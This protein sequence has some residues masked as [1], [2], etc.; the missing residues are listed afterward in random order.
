[1]RARGTKPGRGLRAK[2]YRPAV[3][4]TALG[5]A[6]LAAQLFGRDASEPF[7]HDWFWAA[8]TSRLTLTCLVIATGS[9]AMMAWLGAVLWRMGRAARAKAVNTGQTGSAM[10]EF[11]MVLPILLVF[12]L[13]MTQSALLVTGNVVVHYSAFCAARSAIVQIPRR[14][15]MDEPD[16]MM[17]PNPSGTK[18]RMIRHAAV[19]AVMPVSCGSEMYPPGEAMEAEE[20]VRHLLEHY[21]DEAPPW[22]ASQ[23]A[24]KLNYA[25]EHTEVQVSEPD[26][27]FRYGEAED[28]KVL[29]RH[30][31]WLA[32]PYANALFASLDDGVDLQFAAGERALIIRAACTL[33]NEGVQDYV[34]QETF[35]Q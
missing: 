7:G 31:F 5:A 34:E 12:G 30:E 8:M 20:G 18:M 21:D 13:V 28:V 3:C 15:S 9:L 26:D 24:R 6:L 19:W 1:M 33:T 29:V 11:A 23:L 32:V 16:N 10:L 14:V 2:L 22:V 4:L 27:G 35:P 25:S 17:D